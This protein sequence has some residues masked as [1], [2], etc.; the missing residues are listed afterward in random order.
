M[1][2]QRWTILVNVV[3]LALLT[4]LQRSTALQ[5]HRTEFVLTHRILFPYLP[6]PL[7][8]QPAGVVDVRFF[9]TA[10]SLPSSYADNTQLQSPHD[11]DNAT[12]AAATDDTPTTAQTTT[13]AQSITTG[14]PAPPP[15]S[16]AEL[17]LARDSEYFPTFG[18]VT[19]ATIDIALS[20]QAP[21]MRTDNI[22]PMLF[23]NAVV[24][25]TS[26]MLIGVCTRRQWLQ[27]SE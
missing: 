5:L 20:I 6:L 2:Q 9:S 3:V 14:L 19:G 11:V 13:T 18:L 7:P 16:A 1:L 10:D 23:G 27:V 21:A 17:D 4:Q 25:T 26:V 12:A 22:I 15:A 24:N 8:M